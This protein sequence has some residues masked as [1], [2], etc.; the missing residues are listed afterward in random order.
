MTES[1]LRAIVETAIDEIVFM[2]TRGLAA[3]FNPSCESV[4]SDKAAE[5]IGEAAR[6][7]ALGAEQDQYHPERSA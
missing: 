7:A 2:D 4:F 3:L 6:R 1:R 5:I